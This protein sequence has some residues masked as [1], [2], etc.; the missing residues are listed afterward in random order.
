MLKELI[1]KFYDEDGY[2]KEE[3]RVILTKEEM[4]EVIKEIAGL[5]LDLTSKSVIID[6]L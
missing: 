1:K 4:I 2:L 3:L 6:E 5:N